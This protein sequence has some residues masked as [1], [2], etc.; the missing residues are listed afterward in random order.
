MK[1]VMRL[2][3]GNF[4]MHV[5]MRLLVGDE[6]KRKLGGASIRVSWVLADVRS[7]ILEKKARYVSS[8]FEGRRRRGLRSLQ[9]NRSAFLRSMESK[10]W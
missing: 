10:C 9:R 7:G 1:V 5:A 3:V 6:E 8:C 2:L 4:V